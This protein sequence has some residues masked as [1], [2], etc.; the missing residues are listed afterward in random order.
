MH[1]CCVVFVFKG[2]VGYYA[3]VRKAFDAILQNLDTQIGKPLLQT[4]TTTTR[5]V[6]DLIS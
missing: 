6:D 2:V 3:N 1:C 4:K 5:E